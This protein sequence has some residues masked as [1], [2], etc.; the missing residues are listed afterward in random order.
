MKN[1]S[2]FVLTFLLFASLLFSS[3]AYSQVYNES[4]KMLKNLNDLTAFKNTWGFGVNY[5]EQGVGLTSGLY[6]KLSENTN[7][8]ANI[9]IGG[10]SDS[11][12]FEEVDR[13]GNTIVSNK[14]N[15]IFM[16]PATIGIQHFMFSE[17]LDG[18]FRPYVKAGVM[19]SL[20]LTNPYSKSYFDALGYMNAAFA[21][22]PYAGIGL[23]FMQ[24]QALAFNFTVSYSYLPVIGKK[25]NSLYNTPIKDVGGLQ[26]TFGMDFISRK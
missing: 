5:T 7:L 10:F 16:I 15:R 26:F 4:N 24:S 3:N 23:Q 17:D 20:V 11:R 22:G 1:K 21:M 14:E 12:E 19:P 18:S 9:S 2:F 6:F 13:Y 25:V 8:T